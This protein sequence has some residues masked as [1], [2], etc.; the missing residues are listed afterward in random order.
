M[1]AWASRIVALAFVVISAPLAVIAFPLHALTYC[2]MLLAIGCLTRYAARQQHG[3]LIGTGIAIGIT[4]AGRWDFGVYLVVIAVIILC[5]L[6][7][8][9]ART[10]P[11][12]DSVPPSQFTVVQLCWLLIP[13][14]LT[15]LPVYLPTL[16][17]DPGALLRALD[18]AR[19][20]GMARGLP[21]PLLPNPVGLFLGNITLAD[22]FVQGL[23]TLPN[24]A[25]HVLGPLKLVVIITVLRLPLK[26]RPPCSLVIYSLA[27]TLCGGALFSYGRGRPDFDHTAPM[28]TFMLLSL[29]LLAWCLSRPTQ[30]LS[31]ILIRARRGILGMI[32]VIVVPSVTLGY[33]FQAAGGASQSRAASTFATARLVGM[34]GSS[35]TVR[36]Y[37]AL[38]SEIQR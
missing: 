4:G 18:I 13:A 6:P 5:S 16:L 15:V 27:M 28:T 32:L 11:M 37:D 19:A 9:R 38:V 20:G 3:W 1:R 10:A 35:A 12:A 31:A 2:G 22:F 33:T 34:T 24:Y 21:Y 30:R 36:D 29:P 7:G 14:G 25:F 17:T 8:I 26:D 23:I